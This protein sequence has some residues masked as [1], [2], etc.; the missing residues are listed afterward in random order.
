MINGL[1]ILL[2]L[3]GIWKWPGWTVAVAWNFEAAALPRAVLNYAVGTVV[4]RAL[5]VTTEIRLGVRAR[6]AVRAPLLT[7]ADQTSSA[8]LH[9]CL[10]SYNP[11]T[12]LSSAPHKHGGWPPI[13]R[14]SML[15]PTEVLSQ[16]KKLQ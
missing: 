14:D 4:A 1:R 5:A 8:T 10:A 9:P 3:V 13:P 12:N 16:K 15:T 2:D 7:C 6:R 11:A